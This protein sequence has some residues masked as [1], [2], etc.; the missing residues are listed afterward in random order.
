MKKINKANIKNLNKKKNLKKKVVYGIPNPV[1]L[2]S[3]V[4]LWVIIICKILKQ[5]ME[6]K[7]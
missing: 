7:L 3:K 4:V 6:W 1:C 2:L 5:V